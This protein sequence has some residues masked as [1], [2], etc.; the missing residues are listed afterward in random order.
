M[1]LVVNILVAMIL[2]VAIVSYASDSAGQLTPLMLCLFLA[3]VITA[4]IANV[5]IIL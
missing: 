3:V 4:V 2:L 5:I 1:G